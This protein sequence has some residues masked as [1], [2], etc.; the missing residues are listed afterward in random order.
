M[1]KSKL[2][3]SMENLFCFLPA[4]MKFLPRRSQSTV[5]YLF[6]IAFNNGEMCTGEFKTLE[7]YKQ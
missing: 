2:Q 6:D 3:V 4:Y 5:M 7:I 1:Y